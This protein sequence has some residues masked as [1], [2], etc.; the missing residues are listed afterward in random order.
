MPTNPYFGRPGVGPQQSGAYRNVSRDGKLRY[1]PAGGVIDGTKTRNPFQSLTTELQP[2]LLMGK[3]TSGG[4]W[5]NSVLGVTTGALAGNG[6]SLTVT[7]TQAVEIT[8]RVGTTGTFN[9]TGP[10]AAAG[11]SRTNLVTYSALDTTTGVAT[12]TALAANEVQRINFNIAS[13]GGNLK[14]TVPTVGGGF[15]T[16]GNAAWSATDATYLSNINTALDTATGVTGGIVAT[17]IAAT[18][19]DLGII[20]TYSGGG[21]AGL[22]QAMVTVNTFPTSSTA[23][24]YTRQTTGSSGAFVAASLIQPTDGSEVIRSFIGDGFSVNLNVV[25]AVDVDWPRIP[26]EGIL[27]VDKL[28]PWPADT[29]LRASI[30]AQLNAVGK[31]EFSSNF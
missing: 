7:A 6:T 12:I 11:T 27:D 10:A 15:V 30:L 9:I 1:Y 23:A 22:P 19:T 31:Y 16:T 20:L 25:G 5:A 26:V 28:L 24:T 2:G 14:L 18:D 4:K 13:T 21:Y 8:R 29:G 3:I 17:A